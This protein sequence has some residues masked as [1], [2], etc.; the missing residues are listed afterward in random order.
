M[1][2]F[3]MAL[4]AFAL[5]ALSVSA[6]PL[7]ISLKKGPFAPM[8]SLKPSIAQHLLSIGDGGAEVPITNFLDAQVSSRSMTLFAADAA[9]LYISTQALTDFSCS[10]VLRRDWTGHAGSEVQ[11]GLRYRKLQPVGHVVAL[12]PFQCC[13]LPSQPIQLSQVLYIQGRTLRLPP[14]CS[15]LRHDSACSSVMHRHPVGHRCAWA[16]MDVNAVSRCRLRR[17]QILCRRH[18][19]SLLM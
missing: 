15:C 8:S 18:H 11:G 4:V 3:K 5:S 7:R 19:L 16:C 1:A 17:R 12:Q 10:A 14:P 6:E 13:V 2:S 9:Y